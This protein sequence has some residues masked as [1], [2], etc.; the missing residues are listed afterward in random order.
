MSSKSLLSILFSARNDN[1]YTKYLNR[2]EFILNY[3]LKNIDYYGFLEDVD[4]YIVDWG[5]KQKLSNNIF[6]KDE[7][8]KSKINFVNIDQNFAKKYNSYTSSN[9]FSELAENIGLENIKSDFVIIQPSDQFFS[10]HSLYNLI[11]FL[12]NKKNNLDKM[13]LLQRQILPF[14]FAQQNFTFDILDYFLENL[15]DNNK[16]I[17][18]HRIYSAGGM[19]GFLA[20]KKIFE[21]IGGIKNINLKNRGYFSKSDNEILMRSNNLY[22]YESLT[23]RGILLNKFPYTKSGLRVK[24]NIKIKYNNDEIDKNLIL[25]KNFLVDKARFKSDLKSKFYEFSVFS[26]YRNFLSKISFKISFISKINIFSFFQYNFTS[27]EAINII[28][29][30]EIINRFNVFS[31]YEV[32]E[33]IPKIIY[34][35][36]RANPFYSFYKIFIDKNKSDLDSWVSRMSIFNDVNKSYLKI[37]S[38]NSESINQFNKEIPIQNFSGMLVINTDGDFDYGKLIAKNNNFKKLFSTILLNKANNIDKSEFNTHLIKY[39]KKFFS[40]ELYDFYINKSLNSKKVENL[41]KAKLNKY[42]DNNFINITK[43]FIIVK[44]AKLRLFWFKLKKCLKK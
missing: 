41:L 8:F 19:G 23:K 28:I 26:F 6:V 7:K 27:K 20:K 38:Y 14:D 33:K 12:K 30:N 16:L 29:M 21:K 37:L 31:I 10:K 1:Y 2:L 13:F 3:S 9:F 11:Q 5:S 35:L 32:G 39:Y 34:A 42:K 24:R 17:N 15:N 18:S 36:S 22:P 25:E 43:Y 44:L 4:F 40:T